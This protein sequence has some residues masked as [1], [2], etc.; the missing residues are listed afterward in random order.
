MVIPRILRH[1][2]GWALSQS[3]LLE[4]KSENRLSENQLLASLNF[5]VFG[6][7]R[8]SP[9]ETSSH[10]ERKHNRFA[11]PG[12]QDEQRALHAPHRGGEQ[13]RDGFVLVGAGGEPEGLRP[14]GRGVA[15]PMRLSPWWTGRGQPRGVRLPAPWWP[16]WSAA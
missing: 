4:A 12:G 3:W 10:Q 2:P 1:E 9:S 16:P 11:G 13:G 7:L 5:P 15:V 14:A 6:D 8:Q